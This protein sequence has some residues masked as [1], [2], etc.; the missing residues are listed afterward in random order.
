MK[1]D[2]LEYHLEDPE[3]NKLLDNNKNCMNKKTKIFIIISIIIL[4]IGITILLIF[5]L[6][7]DDDD[8]DVYTGEE[9][10]EKDYYLLK[11]ISTSENKKI[12]N[13]FKEGGENYN[14]ILGN[15]N[16]GND[17]EESERDN[18]DL[19]IP[20]NITKRKDNY[21]WI[22]LIIHGGGWVSGE[23]ADAKPLC[24][25]GLGLITAT[26]SYTLFNGTYRNTNI[27]R[28]IDEISA[29]IKGI[30]LKL[31]EKG[32]NEKKLELV[33]G[34]GSA[35][36]HLSMLYSYMIKHPP[37][38]IKFIQNSVGPA[39]LD[40]RFWLTTKI[41]NDTLDNIDYESIEKAKSEDKL[42]EMNESSDVPMNNFYIIN[43]MNLMLGRNFDDNLEYIFKNKNTY[44]ID[45]EN[46]KY[47]ELLNKTTYAFPIT[48]VSKESIPTLCLYGGQDEMVGIAQYAQLKKKFDENNNKNISLIYYRYGHHNVYEP[49]TENTKIS[50]EKYGQEF[51]IYCQN[52]LTNYTSYFKEINQ[53]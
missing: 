8:D 25:Q 1:D 35:G 6:K 14:P 23:K 21:N 37:L 33:I 28:I 12:R 5:I 41:V 26:M 52:Y 44:E 29:T 30:K 19:C 53:K 45:D 27:F 43:F 16:N 48:Y 42:I 2:D 46:D 36:A 15:I 24:T 18:F 4:I 3:D 38:P 17:Y 49:Y 34:G 31:K 9:D 13:S 39:T 7:E 11:N 51:L 20:Y 22:L 50:D 40:H 47:K 10:I 32:F